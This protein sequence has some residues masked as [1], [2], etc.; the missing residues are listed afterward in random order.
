MT[1]AEAVLQTIRERRTIK[2]KEFLQETIS[3][4][5][6]AE[7]LESANWAPNHGKTEPWRL[8]VFTG[9]EGIKKYTGII[10]KVFA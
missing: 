8:T 7:I 4:E 5:V 1:K 10:E 2:P 6:I 3:D 9:D